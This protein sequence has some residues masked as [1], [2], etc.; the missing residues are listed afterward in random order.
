MLKVM[1]TALVSGALVALT[2]H[3]VPAQI[4]SPFVKCSAQNG[5]MV[6]GKCELPAKPEA[7]KPAEQPAQAG[8]RA[9]APSGGRGEQGA[10]QPQNAP[11]ATQGRGQNGQQGGAP[12]TVQQGGTQ[13]EGGR[14][15]QGA[16]PGGQQTAP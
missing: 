6:D 16:Q 2:A 10:A 11:Q 4:F 14:G 3:P 15:Q 1:K 8:P 5:R 9:G 13:R 12:A 7:A